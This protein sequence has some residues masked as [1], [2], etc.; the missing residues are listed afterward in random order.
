MRTEDM[1]K[2]L[3]FCDQRTFPLLYAFKQENLEA[4]QE[5]GHEVAAEFLAG[6][7]NLKLY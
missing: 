3:D 4:Q 1:I 2:D 6:K 7:G 5:L